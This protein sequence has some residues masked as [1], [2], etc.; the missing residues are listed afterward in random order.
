MS[1]WGVLVRVRDTPG[2]LERV[3]GLA[4]RRAMSLRTESVVRAF[5]GLWSVVFQCT[6]DG[7]P[8]DHYASEFRELI[9]LHEAVPL[10]APQRAEP[11]P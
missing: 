8:I 10:R 2:S 1:E 5:D 3:L 6:V 9:D 4:R 7:A 11:V